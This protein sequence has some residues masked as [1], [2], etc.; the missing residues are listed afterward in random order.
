MTQSTRRAGLVTEL[1]AQAR[2]EAL[3][4][5][6]LALLGQA[7]LG[8]HHLPRVLVQLLLEARGLRLL[9][10]PPRLGLVGLALGLVAQLRP[11]PLHL[12]L[13]A[14]AALL[15]LLE[16]AL[17]LALLPR[18]LLLGRL[19]LGLQLRLALLEQR[20]VAHAVLVEGLQQR[21]RLLLLACLALQV[22]LELPLARLELFALFGERRVDGRASVIVQAA[23]GRLA[24]VLQLPLQARHRGRQRL[25]LRRLGLD[26]LLLLGD[27]RVAARERLLRVGAHVA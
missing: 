5:L 1:A 19:D 17:R 18:L 7:R 15:K 11:Q 10:L 2:E 23:H 25:D 16:P 22:S 8:L 21:R 3:A 12:G 13:L 14:L 27:G 20:R 9:C 4:A 24:R 6:L 26:L